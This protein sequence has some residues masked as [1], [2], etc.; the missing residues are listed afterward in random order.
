MPAFIHSQVE[1]KYRCVE[2]RTWQVLEI[3]TVESMS[4]GG[5]DVEST[6]SQEVV[7][8]VLGGGLLIHY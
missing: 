3:R 6:E 2:G 7:T 1:N 4:S 5:V 8:S